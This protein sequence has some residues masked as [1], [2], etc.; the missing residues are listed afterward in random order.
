MEIHKYADFKGYHLTEKPEEPT[1]NLLIHFSNTGKSVEAFRFIIDGPS[2]DIDFKGSDIFTLE[3]LQPF[4]FKFSVDLDYIDIKLNS[5]TSKWLDITDLIARGQI[6]AFINKEDKSS[7]ARKILEE[8]HKSNPEVGAALRWSI[9]AKNND[10]LS[11]TLQ[12][13]PK[14]ATKLKRDSKLCADEAPTIIL[15]AITANTPL[16]TCNGFSI[17]KPVLFSKDPST[18]ATSIN[19]EP[20]LIHK[21]KLNKHSKTNV[22]FFQKCNPLQSNYQQIK[23][24]KKQATKPYHKNKQTKC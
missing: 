21:G 6:S 23:S 19:K 18:L 2:T 12:C 24:N 4:L 5:T 9:Q 17:P 3:S 22:S 14:P 1:A 15:E 10:T 7:E 16:L 20:A 8:A 11:I 13:L